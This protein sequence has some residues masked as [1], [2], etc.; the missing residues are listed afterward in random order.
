M[1]NPTVTLKFVYEYL[2]ANEDY[3]QL[4]YVLRHGVIVAI[5]NTEHVQTHFNRLSFTV[6]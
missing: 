1:E 4:V 2:H 3:N 5:R 6:H